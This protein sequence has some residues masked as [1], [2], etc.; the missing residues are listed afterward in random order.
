MSRPYNISQKYIYVA[1]YLSAASSLT[2]P[3]LFL[4]HPLNVGPLN[5]RHPLR[6]SEQEEGK[7]EI[8]KAPLPT[9][10]H[11]RDVQNMWT[12]LV[13]LVLIVVKCNANITVTAVTAASSSPAE[14]GASVAEDLAAYAW[15]AYL[16]WLCVPVR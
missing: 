3:K 7:C 14:G 12:L 10:R 4:G 9:G 6:P 15:L 2:L 11:N 16:I 1:L 8:S 5:A 13:W